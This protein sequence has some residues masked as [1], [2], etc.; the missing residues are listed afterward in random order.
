MDGFDKILKTHGWRFPKGY[1]DMNDP[2]DK[3]KAF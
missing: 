3:K 2:K 1:P